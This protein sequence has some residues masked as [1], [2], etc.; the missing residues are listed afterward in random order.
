MPEWCSSKQS[1]LIQ[2]II[3]AIEHEFTKTS[4]NESR[5]FIFKCGD[6]NGTE[7]S[8]LKSAYNLSQLNHEPT[9]NNKCLD[10]ILTNS[11][12]CYFCTNLMPIGNSDH[13]TISAHVSPSVYKKLL[14]KCIKQ[15]KRTGKIADTVTT[16]KIADT[17]RL[18]Y[19]QSEFRD[20]VS[21]KQKFDL[22]YSKIKD[23]ENQNQPIKMIKI[24]NDKPWMADEL[25]DM[26]KICQSLYFR[27]HVNLT[28]PKLASD[29]R[30]VTL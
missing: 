12:D 21:I 11:P 2:E 24:V 4:S 10:I 27:S 9:R 5:T 26:I 8:K 3:A 14:P 17:I 30:D 22:F 1:R 16:G 13:Q 7:V 18:V 19:W 15:P 25:R 6:L 28:A 23:I 29:C 20:I